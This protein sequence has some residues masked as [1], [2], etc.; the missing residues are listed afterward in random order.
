MKKIILVATLATIFVACKNNSNPPVYNKNMVLVDTTGLSKSNATTDAAVKANNNNTTTTTV[1]T[2]RSAGP[3]HARASSHA[4]YANNGTTQPV[5]TNTAPVTVAPV[6]TPVPQ[7]D[8]GWS[9][10]AKGTAIGAGTG[11]VVGAIVSKNKATGAIIGAVIGGGGGY[12]I[13]RARDRKSGR[14]A[15]HRARKAAGY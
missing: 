3:Q 6:A 8:K 2:T 14:V 13:G 7:K 12:A 10:A 4:V 9:D 1:T 5:S 11:A 15:R